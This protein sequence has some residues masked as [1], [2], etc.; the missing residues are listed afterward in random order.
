MV[1]VI[2]WFEVV[3]F[4]V[5]VVN[6]CHDVVKIVV[7]FVIAVDVVIVLSGTT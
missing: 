4:E 1:V 6:L 3:I 5:H 2:I 7:D